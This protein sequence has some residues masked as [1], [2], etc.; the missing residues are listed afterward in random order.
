MNFY[1]IEKRSVSGRPLVLFH[2]KPHKM[3]TPSSPNPK[4]SSRITYFL[5]EFEVRRKRRASPS[6]SRSVH[7][8]FCLNIFET[9]TDGHWINCNTHINPIY[10]N[11]H[12]TMISGWISILFIPDFPKFVNFS[13]ENVGSLTFASYESINIHDDDGVDVVL[14]TNKQFSHVINSPSNLLGSKNIMST[15][16]LR[17]N[18]NQWINNNIILCTLYILFSGEAIMPSKVLVIRKSSTFGN[19]KCFNS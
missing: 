5:L 12:A 10:S 14:L 19:T 16:W 3:T 7:S 6:L 13:L 2:V 9:R 8:Y 4:R 15:W 1:T 11:L 18:I 17:I